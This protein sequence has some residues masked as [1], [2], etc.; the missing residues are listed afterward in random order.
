[1]VFNKKTTHFDVLFFYTLN[2]DEMKIYLD[3]VL[4]LN[5]LLDFILLL[6]VAFILKR[7][8]RFERI[9]ISSF[10]GSLTVLLLFIKIDMFLL[11]TI[12]IFISILMI[13]I[14]FSFKSFK[15]F[16]NN[17]LFLYINSILLGGFIYFI[18]YNISS[19]FISNGLVIN[20]IALIILSPIII[21]LYV[22][23]L[24]KIKN[25]YNNYYDVDIY[26]NDSKY[27]FV[28]YF[29]SA[30]NLKYKNKPVILINEKLIH[31]VKFNL[32]PYQALN[33]T[34]LL[35]ITK[36]DKLYVNNIL[37]NECYLG[38]MEHDLKIDG[39]D[40][41]L[42]NQLGGIIWLKKLLIYLK[43]Y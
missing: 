9:T 14:T 31:N 18:N 35:K 43:V 7:K 25:N 1:M 3:L 13:L 32:M 21:Y 24:K 2:G 29:D 23:E 42:N 38:M 11:F 16:F 34:G 39:V 5:F 30:N 27:S 41:L 12:K 19:S 4:I 10:L 36:I 28:G 6:S 26:I 37:I 40:V 15:Y 33:Y 8:I 20:F 17:F 22:H